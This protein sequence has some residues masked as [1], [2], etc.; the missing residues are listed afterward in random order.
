MDVD[1]NGKRVKCKYCEKIV[2]GGVYRFKN[3]LACTRIDVELCS[4]V[5][6]EVKTTK[7]CSFCVKQNV[8]HLKGKNKSLTLK[9]NVIKVYKLKM[10]L[11]IQKMG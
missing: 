6:Q 3:H 10:S 1:G 2:N 4:N 8:L 9:K 5:P 7:S 11:K